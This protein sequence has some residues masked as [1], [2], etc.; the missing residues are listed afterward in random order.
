MNILVVCHYGLYED[1]SFSFVHAQAKAYTAIGHNVKVLVPVAVAKPD[2][3]GKRLKAHTF[4]CEGVIIVP[5]RYVSLSS[6]GEKRFNM[7]SVIASIKLQLPTILDG[8]RPDIIHAHTLGFDSEIGKY[9]KQKLGIP[10]VV[11]THGSDCAIPYE[12]GRLEFLRSCC[13]GVDHIVSVSSALGNKLRTCGTITPITA[14]LNGYAAQNCLGVREKKE[15]SFLQ[16]GHLQA[17]K[18][19]AITIQAFA[20]IYS[21]YPNAR[22]TMIGAGPERERLELLCKELGIQDM[23]R[24]T[25]QLSNQ[26]VLSEMAQTQFFV[27]PSVREGLGIVYLEAMASACITIGTEEEGIADVITS[28]ENGFLVPPDDS[29]AIVR[30]VE[31]CLMHSE[32]AI[33]IAAHGRTDATELTWERNAQKYV[34]LFEKLTR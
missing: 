20:K 33:K 29:D 31:W 15:F 22:L 26:E 14:I 34:Q 12:Q 28:G 2:W 17:Q 8:F 7:Q 32:E 19:P 4:E 21:I 24:F 23:V 5:V 25:G 1:L 10:L 16:V 27:M 30:I 18:R 3:T 11:T 9:L 6:Y 13:D